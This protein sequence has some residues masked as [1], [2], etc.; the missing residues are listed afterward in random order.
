MRRSTLA[1]AKSQIDIYSSRESYDP[2][3]TEGQRETGDNRAQQSMPIDPHPPLETGGQPSVMSSGSSSDDSETRRAEAKCRVAL[4]YQR[5]VQADEHLLHLI[6]RV[7]AAKGYHVFV[8]HDRVFGMGWAQE[9]ERQIRQADVVIPLLSENLAENEMFAFEVELAHEASQKQAH[10]AHFLPVRVNYGGPLPELLAGIL[11]PVPHL[12]WQ[13]PQDDGRFTAELLDRFQNFAAVVGAPPPKPAA[14][15][16]LP[17]ALVNRKPM[18]ASS[19][20]EP[21]SDLEPAGGAVPLSSKYYVARGADSEFRS[22]IS[23]KDSIILV[24]GA[25]QMGKTSLLARGLQQAR[26]QGDRVVLTDLQKL[27]AP[28]F[29]SADS[30]YRILAEVIADQLGLSVSP[31][32]GWDVRRGANMNFERF[33]RRE[34]LEKLNAPLVWGIDEVDRLFGCPFG[35]EVFALFRS[36]HNDRALDPTGPWNSLVLAIAYAT[37]AHLFIRDLNQSPFNVGTRL[38]LDDFNRE[39]VVDL[40]ERYDSPLKSPGEIAR[41]NRLVGGQPYLVCR[42]LYEMMNQQMGID[43]L[44]LQSDRDEGIYGDHLRRILVLLAKDIDL[45][46]AVR[47]VLAGQP[48]PTPESFYR[49]RSA[50]LLQGTSQRDAYPRCQIY[51]TYLAKHLL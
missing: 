44:E 3:A 25:R 16:V 6:E 27:N 4:I 50:G 45:C 51:A 26:R 42:G 18:P 15:R 21:F 28:H 34:V 19:P 48:C 12:A 1:S 14:L 38:A 10:P 39:Q 7:L 20:E 22:A 40:N 49:L 23:R 46:D 30:L 11:N 9:I 2:M 43:Q 37:E 36:W 41:F 32:S 8:D 35:T 29:A 47:D 5:N 17:R 31:G 24:K 33:M 13:G